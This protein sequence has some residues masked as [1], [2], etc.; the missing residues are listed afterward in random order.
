M[1]SKNKLKYNKQ[2]K[3]KKRCISMLR[4]AFIKRNYYK[5]L[6]LNDTNDNETLWATVKPF[7]CIKISMK[8]K[9]RMVNW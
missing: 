5:N 6:D 9:M 3:A 8:N 4:K 1:T 7:L 2:R